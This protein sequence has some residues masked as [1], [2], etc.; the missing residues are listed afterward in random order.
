MKKKGMDLEFFQS[1]FLNN[2]SNNKNN[3]NLNQLALGYA[4]GGAI[5]IRSF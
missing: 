2:N 1:F 3:K 5:R 4:S